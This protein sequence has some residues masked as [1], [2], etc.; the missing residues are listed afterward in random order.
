MELPKFQYEF[1]SIG[2]LPSKNHSTVFYISN[3]STLIEIKLLFQS[4]LIY[5]KYS[6]WEDVYFY[7]CNQGVLLP[8]VLF[9][10]SY[11]PTWLGS[12]L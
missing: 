7:L 9:I 5:S 3:L 2:H 8:G 4:L 12:I 6:Q 10:I 11:F 1:T